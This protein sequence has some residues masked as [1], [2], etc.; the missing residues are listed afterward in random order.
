V[1]ARMPQAAPGVTTRGSWASPPCRTQNGSGAC[2]D[3]IDFAP[4][5]GWPSWRPGARRRKSKSQGRR[6]CR[7]RTAPVSGQSNRY[8]NHP[9]EMSA[10]PDNPTTV[11]RPH[12]GVPIEKA[13]ERSRPSLLLSR[14]GICIR[15]A[16]PDSGT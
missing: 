13:R 5:A 2:P 7:G 8:G 12:G 14:C 11:H 15:D 6:G 4:C 1:T 10:S 3:R 16:L 9:K